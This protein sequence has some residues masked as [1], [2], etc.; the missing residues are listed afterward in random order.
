MKSLITRPIS[1]GLFIV[2][3]TVMSPLGASQSGSERAASQHNRSAPPATLACEHNQLTSWDGVVS[4]YKRNA[5]TTTITIHTD[6][7][8]VESATLRHPGPD[9][10]LPFLLLDGQPFTH[11]DWSRIE[12]SNG[13]LVEGTRAIVWFCLD[14]HTQ[15]VIDWRP[16]ESGHRPRRR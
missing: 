10:V 4:H 2:V 9:G 14:Q 1:C 16:M 15:A 5:A 7:D 13:M 8:T 6:W 11:D 3:I 12:Q